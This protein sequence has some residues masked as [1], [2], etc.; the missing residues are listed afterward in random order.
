LDFHL[1]NGPD[2]RLIGG[3]LLVT[4]TLTN[5]SAI[6]PNFSSKPERKLPIIR[7]TGLS[8]M[9]K[10]IKIFGSGT[11]SP[12][13]LSKAAFGLARNVNVAKPRTLRKV[14]FE[15]FANINALGSSFLDD[16]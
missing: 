12:G 7:E 9:I 10:L 1:R 11:G 6:F 8:G 4:S 5:H 16:Q 13:D 14:S 2:D 15:D 3:G